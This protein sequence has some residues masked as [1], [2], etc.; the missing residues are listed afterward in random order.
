MKLKLEGEK[1]TG[2]VTRPGRQGGEPVTTEIKEAKLKGDEISFI[3][4]VERG[5]NTFTTKYAGKISGDAIKGK[6]EAP[7]RDGQTNSRDWEA[8]READKK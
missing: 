1:V 8:K 7:G 4:S 6:I 5:G 2:A 3:T